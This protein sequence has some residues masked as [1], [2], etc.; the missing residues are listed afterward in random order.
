[1][2]LDL[3]IADVT[4]AAIQM[5]LDTAAL[6]F[7][8]IPDPF[9]G[10]G[11]I[12]VAGFTIPISDI[13]AA[14]SKGTSIAMAI[15]RAAMSADL[16]GDGLRDVIEN[17]ITGTDHNVFDTDGDGLGDGYEVT[18]AGGFYGGTRRP[19]PNNPDSDGDGLLDGE[20]GR[21]N[22]SFCLADTDCDTLT[23]GEEVG[24]WLLGDVRDHAD[25]LLQDTDGDGIPDD[26]EYASSSC[27][28]VNE[29]FV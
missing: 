4:L 2:V 27:T 11:I 8:V 10:G 13:A 29:E 17:T 3:N 24:T 23:D 1:M 28:Y 12:V 25:P 26:I 21:Y 15:A 22:T 19:D 7:D 16:D 6:V 14:I 18:A 20:E 9:A 5:E